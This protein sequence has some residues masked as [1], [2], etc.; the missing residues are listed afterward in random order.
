MNSDPDDDAP[1]PSRIT[2]RRVVMVIAFVVLGLLVLATLAEKYM[3]RKPP[4]PIQQALD[5]V[6]NFRNR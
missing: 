5:S 4:A 1:R 6:R 3:G 2:L